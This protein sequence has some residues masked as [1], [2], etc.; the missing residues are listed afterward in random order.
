MRKGKKERKRKG[1]D[2]KERHGGRDDGGGSLGQSFETPAS[3][4]LNQDCQDLLC[5]NILH[6]K[7]T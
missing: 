1:Q 6:I 4:R 7:S 2:R 3:F 5:D